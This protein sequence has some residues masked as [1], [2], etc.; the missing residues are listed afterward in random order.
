LLSAGLV[1]AASNPVFAQ[2]APA[3]ATAPA[4]A[5]SLTDAI[6]AALR[7]RPLLAADA[8]RADA[9]RFRVNQAR[10]P[11][12]PRLDLQF[13][14]SEGLPGAP[15]VFIGGLA[16]SPFK[17]HVGGSVTLTQ[18]LLDFGRT[19]SNVRARQAEVTA[20]EQALQAD[21]Q[22]V[23]LEVQQAYLQALQ[24][25]RLVQVNEQIREQRR[26]VARQ[27]ETLRANGLASRV[28]VELA[29]VQVSQAELA[30]VSARNEVE[31]GFAALS[32][33]MGRTVPSTIRLGDVA[34][35]AEGAVV[36]VE[37]AIA[38]ALK[39][40]P[41]L[42]QLDAQVR[43]EESRISAA[44]AGKKPLLNALASV[45]KVNPGPLIK[46]SDDPYAVA[47]ILAFPLFTGGLVEGQIGEAQRNAAA[48]RSQRDELANQVRRQVVSTVANLS[49]SEQSLRVARLQLVRAQD[50]LNLSTQRY[51]AQL[52]SI[53]ELSQAQAVFA[54]AQND[55][56]RAQYD[57][58]L[59]RA[60]LDFAT[61][62]APAGLPEGKP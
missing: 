49:A 26:L 14:A 7:E 41:E 39:Q 33:A 32:A 34:A 45:G 12:R 58:E 61:G 21:R 30:V 24:A 8:S 53:V 31:N 20:S 35:G 36:E 55:L 52:G 17:K 50:A 46:D 11:L 23:V 56:I 2:A 51:Q 44:R 60:A 59:A 29:E 19:R 4:G 22:Q 37:G 57:R 5:L 25:Q 54:T 48:A 28:D 40:R 47:V 42:R 13:S 6:S 27:A 43:A 15:Q 1:A 16:G 9:A 3:A 38:D 62:R 18:T 10:A